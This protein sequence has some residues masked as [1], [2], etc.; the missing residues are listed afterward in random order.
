MSAPPA[1][2]GPESEAGLRDRL[3]SVQGLLALS[4]VM[5]ESGDEQRILHLATTSVPSLGD[6]RLDGVYLTGSGWRITRGPC[7]EPDVRADIEAQFAVL[8]SAGGTVAITGEG[9]G[10]AFP[11]RSLDGHFG[12]LLVAADRQPP[13]FVQFLL[14]V[15]AQQSGIALGNARLHARERATTAQLREANAT[16]AATVAAFERRTAIHDRLNRVAVVGAG[17]EGV[18]SAVHELTGYAVAVEDRTGGLLA[19]AGPARP[20]P[21]DTGSPGGR[22]ELLRQA[23]RAGVPIRDGARLFAIAHPRPDVLG[24]L[25]LFDPEGHAGEHEQRALEHGV[26]VLAIELARMHILAE[27]E[28]RLG[29]DVVDELLAG[30]E[31]G[32]VLARAQSL[33]YAVE[34]PHRVIVIE[35]PELQHD[36][37]RLYQAVRRAAHDIGIG[38]FLLSQGPVVVVLSED[39]RPWDE[40]RQ[41]VREHLHGSRCRLGVG[42]RCVRPPDFPRSR[43]EA[44][45]A[46]KVQQ[47]AGLTDRVT[48]FDKLGIYRI[49]ADVRR[50]DNVELFVREWLG[51]LLDYDTDKR[52]DLVATLARYLEHGGNYDATAKAVAVH[53]STLKYRL[54]RI[55]QISGHDLADP[56]TQFNLQLATRARQTLLAMGADTA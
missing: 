8:S 41:A 12:Y 1:Y 20:E 31:S 42:G 13:A 4:M 52:T 22:D 24:V 19:W 46:L 28:L 11:L 44:E 15:L 14:R 32:H 49:L 3:S 18:A 36:G 54:Q 35:S 37:D 51:S 27:T 39:D 30:N 6:C 16:L 23:Q 33:G 47:S 34:R 25:V 45:L 29:R 38:P 9:W 17:L 40:F 50:P 7:T 53:R 56:D 43:H 48:V 21:Y 2:G 26:T 55:R 5:T 10:A